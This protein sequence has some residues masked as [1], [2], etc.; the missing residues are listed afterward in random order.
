M[1]LVR[2]CRPVAADQVRS[3]ALQYLQGRACGLRFRDVMPQFP[4]LADHGISRGV[5]G[6]YDEDRGHLA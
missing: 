5:I 4:E 3:P 2:R 6:I 1:D